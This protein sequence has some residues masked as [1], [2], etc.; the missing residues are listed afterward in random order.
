MLE[1]AL[2]AVLRDQAQDSGALWRILSREL[3]LP[4]ATISTAHGGMGGGAAETWVIMESLGRAPGWTPY[5]SSVVLGA[6][7]LRHAGGILAERLLPRVATGDLQLAFAYL[8]EGRRNA[9]KPLKVTA[10][11]ADGGHILHGK[12]T[13]VLGLGDAEMIIVSACSDNG[14]VSL[15]TVDARSLGL[16]ISLYPT[17]DGDCGGD[18]TF[19]DV[20]VPEDAVTGP[21]GAA[22]PLLELVIDEATIALC[23]AAC[24]TMRTLVDSTVAYCRERRQFGKA[25]AEFQVI[26]H[27]LVDMHVAAEQAVGITQVG[28]AKL[29]AAPAERME[30]VSGAKVLVSQACRAV[31]QGAV[32]LHGGIGTTEELVISRYFKRA[33]MMENLFGNAAFHLHRYQQASAER[34]SQ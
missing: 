22:L 3:G 34:T 4:A 15:F 10:T 16:S 1:A 21:P 26:Q 19:T 23:A 12:K 24:G 29:D 6:G 18:V 25:I 2:A 11:R 20:F 8:E 32:Q 31:A 30:A 33:L 27:R 13:G 9:I 17:L 5:L 7:A 28:L 14:G